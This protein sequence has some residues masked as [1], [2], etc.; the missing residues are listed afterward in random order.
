MNTLDKEFDTIRQL[1]SPIQKSQQYKHSVKELKEGDF[2]TIEDLT[3]YV[4]EL[5]T[6][7]E[8]NKSGKTTWSWQ[9]MKLFC[10]EKGTTSYLEYEEDDALEIYFCDTKIKLRELGIKIE[11]IKEYCD[12][13][14]GAITFKGKK[15]NYEDDYKAYFI[16]KNAEASPCMFY[17]FEANDGTLLSIEEWTDEAGSDYEVFISKEIE[18]KNISIISLG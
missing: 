18:A 14:E 1:H 3:Y 7:E 6:Y 5:Y 16:K 13:E 8:R 17:D 2:F 11:T 9:E 12:D 15:F 4:E 10:I